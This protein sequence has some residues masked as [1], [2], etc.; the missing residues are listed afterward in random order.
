[1]P[2][3]ASWLAR[4]PEIAA[5][6]RGTETPPFLDR[7]AFERLFRIRRRQAIRLMS[8]SG[9]YQVGKTYLVPREQ[10]L[11]Y[12]DTLL[13]DGSVAEARQCKQRIGAAIEEIASRNE[14]RQTRIRTDADKL[15]RRSPEL[16]AA[17]ELVAPGKVQISYRDAE[18]LLARIVELA[19]AAS[20]DFPGFRKLYEGEP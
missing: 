19:A 1:M 6:L 15:L 17:V 9:G 13:A 3:Q 14:A 18:D 8:H 2:A 7:P 12:L 20:S 16:P 11:A 4:V 5:A 10:L